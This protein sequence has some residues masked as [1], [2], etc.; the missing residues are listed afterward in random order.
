MPSPAS[1]EPIP[2]QDILALLETS[3]IPEIEWEH[4]DDLCDCTFQRIGTWTNPYIG[5]SLK[6]RLCCI[7][8]EI[9]K[10]YPQFVQ[11]IPAYY[12]LSKKTYES[13]PRDWDA[14][15]SDMPKA[16]WHR[17]VAVLTRT[18]L[19]RVRELLDGQEPPKAIGKKQDMTQPETKGEGKDTE[20]RPE[21]V[22]ISKGHQFAI[23]EIMRQKN[24]LDMQLAE[25]MR[26][27]G[28]TPGKT[29]RIS[30]DGVA[31]EA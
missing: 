22:V 30:R 9:Y 15:D 21:G 2:G 8:A 26:E 23:E 20:Q 3:E 19:T 28:L 4:G 25:I 29:Y 31:T 7:W 27:A 14:E 17:H 12:D 24:A 6:V 11:E 16:L 13:K 1:A 5:R 18:P 10:Q